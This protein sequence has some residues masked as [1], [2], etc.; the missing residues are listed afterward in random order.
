MGNPLCKHCG[1]PMEIESVDYY[2][3]SYECKCEGYIKEWKLKEE[4]STIRKALREK[5]TE[6]ENHINNS[7]YECTIREFEN[8]IKEFKKQYEERW[9]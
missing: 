1:E 3:A 7:L 4:L 6:L 8:K 2:G 9:F 5:E